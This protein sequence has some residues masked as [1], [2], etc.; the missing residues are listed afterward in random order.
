[1]LTT[2]LPTTRK[3]SNWRLTREQGARISASFQI[4]TC[5]RR[6]R[7][8]CLNSLLTRGVTA[9]FSKL[10]NIS[11]YSSLLP[12]RPPSGEGVEIK[13]L[14]VEVGVVVPLLPPPRQ[15]ELFPAL[16]WWTYTANKW[17]L[18]KL[19]MFWFLIT[20]VIQ[21][22]PTETAKIT[23]VTLNNLLY[24]YSMTLPLFVSV[25][26]LKDWQKNGKLQRESAMKSSNSRISPKLLARVNLIWAPFRDQVSLK[27]WPRFSI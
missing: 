26:D 27:I 19:A 20:S 16:F 22:I 10:T 25:T 17:N 21:E 15:T 7:L 12:G 9:K 4:F 11:I 18:I 24:I 3:W 1:M 2:F 13:G 8:F 23:R 14:V 5:A 6:P